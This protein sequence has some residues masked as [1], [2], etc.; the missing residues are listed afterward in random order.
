MFGDVVMEVP[1]KSFNEIFDGKK[2]EVK[3]EFDVDL[4]TEDLKDII[5]KYKE[6]Y[7]KVLGVNFLRLRTSN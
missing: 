4:T 3:A 6:L 7:E 5:V 1:M 2:A